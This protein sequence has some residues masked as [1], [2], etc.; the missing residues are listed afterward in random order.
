M[1][2][3]KKS[4]LSVL[5][6]AEDSLSTKQIRG[7]LGLKKSATA[8]LKSELQ[9]LI[10]DRKIKK[11]GTH[12]FVGNISKEK[13]SSLEK[14]KKNFRNKLISKKHSKI[15]KSK[16]TRKTET[17]YFTRNRKGFGF[18]NIGYARSDIFV[19]ENDQGF[20]MEGDLVKIQIHPSRG[21][22]G[23]R[24]GKIVRIVERAS[25]EIFARIEK[26]N[27]ETIAIPILKN[28]GL[29]FFR[30]ANKNY[31]KKL[32][33]GTL[34]E[35]E[36]LEEN[37][38][39]NNNIDV[40]LVKILRTLDK[41][42]NSD[43][44]IELI[45]KENLIRTN[46]PEETKEYLK[47]FSQKVNFD[48]T[49]GRNDLRD[50]FFVT[51]D[52]K[53]ARDF[54]DAVCVI[55]N[56]DSL[57]G[58]RLFVSIAD[59]SH[60]V[61][62]EDPVDKEAFLR[63]TS[64][65]FPRHAIHMLPEELSNNLCSLRPKVNR[66]TLTCE[67]QINSEGRVE[68]YSI[69]ESIIRSRARL[70]YE[71]VA[72]FLD[73]NNSSIKDDLTKSNLKK[74]HKLAK[75][76]ERKRLRRG[77]IQF[78]FSEEVFKFDKDKHLIGIDYSYQSSS[79]KLIEQF[80]LEANETVAEHCLKNNIPSI[81][82]VHNSPEKKKLKKLQKIFHR[83]GLKK[84]ISS[85]VESKKFNDLLEKIKN[86]PN[87][88]QLQ[89]FLLRSMP[90]AVYET[91]NKGHFGLAAEYYTHFTS[92][93][94][95]YPDL[96][97][98]RAIKKNIYSN[99]SKNT[100]KKIVIKNE[101]AEICSQQERRAEKAERQSIDLIKVDFMSR[102]VGQ[103]FQAKVSLIESHGFRIIIESICFEWFIT[104]E[105]ITNDYFIFDENLNTLLSHRKNLVLKVGQSLEI[106]LLSA[107]HISR[108]LKFK[109]EHWLNQK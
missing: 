31:L 41:M 105:C 100:K 1:K 61:K 84:S 68:S 6:K 53:N 94:R 83:F 71:D 16:N 45:I 109:I 29:T 90:L 80:M 48:F 73:G 52:G 13:P 33:H 42:S 11:Q 64:V 99:Q 76:L 50:L 70:N 14:T 77:A 5:E 74:M 88:E 25:N 98:H 21:F 12:Y 72:D 35:V 7:A 23:K 69:Y 103:T 26:T 51:I 97:V 79:M 22:R 57:G 86:L 20:A 40:P 81:Y 55:E 87:F 78:N 36:L 58:F 101:V 39:S 10:N 104:L 85:L 38:K 60:Y 62:S 107:D 30:I 47:K 66:L 2:S 95:R 92:P 106:L 59:V 56:K 75:I 15:K 44:G 27:R 89:I 46:F 3:R 54:D 28:K 82:R 49:S 8:K 9:T 18:V 108:T 93:I 32:K 91:K 63:G 17:G 102:Y 4:I 24:K 19:G 65:Y 43:L 37:N 67:M 96:L 34:I